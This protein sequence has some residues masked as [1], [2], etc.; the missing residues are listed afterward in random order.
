MGV[1]M[2]S[3]PV[4]GVVCDRCGVEEIEVPFLDG[5]VRHLDNRIRQRGWRVRGGQDICSV[6]VER[7]RVEMRHGA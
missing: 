6:C 7:E 4:V 5:N 2:R 3:D 1:A